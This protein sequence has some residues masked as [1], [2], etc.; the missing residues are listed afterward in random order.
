VVTE[1]IVVAAAVEAGLTHKTAMLCAVM[2]KAAGGAGNLQQGRTARM[3]S[4]A[5]GAAAAAVVMAGLNAPAKRACRVCPWVLRAGVPVKLGLRGL[6]V[7]LREMMISLF[8]QGQDPPLS[9]V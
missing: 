6:T 9:V 3:T 8:Q 7:V 5:G 2:H 4:A 1:R